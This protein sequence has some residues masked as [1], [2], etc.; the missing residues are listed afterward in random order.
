VRDRT[1]ANRENHDRSVFLPKFCPPPRCRLAGLDQLQGGGMAGLGNAADLAALSQL[2]AAGQARRPH[3]ETRAYSA[4]PLATD[5]LVASSHQ[6]RH[7]RSLSTLRLLT[8]RALCV[9]LPDASS[10]AAIAALGAA[11]QAAGLDGGGT[12]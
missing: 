9:Q 7:M 11:S 12:A 3:C 2:S 5:F 10:A 6:S 4:R 1:E 8:A